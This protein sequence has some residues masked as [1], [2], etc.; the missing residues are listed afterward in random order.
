M[1]TICDCCN[2]FNIE[3]A[4]DDLIREKSKFKN[5]LVYIIY[6]IGQ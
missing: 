1:V 4:G 5:N 6:I 2:L 3:I